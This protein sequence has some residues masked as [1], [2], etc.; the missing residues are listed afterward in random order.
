MTEIR[1]V[2]KA[3]LNN[4]TYLLWNIGEDRC[5]DEDF[6]PYDYETDSIICPYTR[7]MIDRIGVID[8]GLAATPKQKWEECYRAARRSL[9]L[10]IVESDKTFS[11]VT[12]NY[13]DLTKE[14]ELLVAKNLFDSI[15]VEECDYEDEDYEYEF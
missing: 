14:E 13:S 11:G 7:L 15:E 12:H 9:V 2:V 6:T 3:N 1:H 10:D 4:G 5:F 8:A